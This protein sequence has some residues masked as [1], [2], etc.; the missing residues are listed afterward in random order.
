MGTSVFDDVH[1]RQENQLPKKN[2]NTRITEKPIKRPMRATKAKGYVLGQPSN[3]CHK[4]LNGRVAEVVK[5]HSTVVNHER[6]Y[7]TI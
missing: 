4:R 5:G 7:Q 1:H 3:S 2:V 6:Q